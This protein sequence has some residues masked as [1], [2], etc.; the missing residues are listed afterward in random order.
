MNSGIRVLHVIGGPVT[1]GA[2]RGALW[3]HSGLRQRG[4]SSRVLVQKYAGSDAGIAGM[5]RSPMDNL[6]QISRKTLDSLPSLL[7]VKEKGNYFSPGIFG[8]DIRRHPWFD[9]ADMIHLHWINRAALNLNILSK[10]EKPIIWTLRDMWPMT[11]GCHYS[12]S[13]RKYEQRCGYCPQLKLR[14]RWDMSRLLI[15]RK[16]KLYPKQ[17]YPVAISHWLENCARQSYLLKDY[18]L[19]TIHNGIDTSVFYPVEK[20]D[21]RKTLNL[22]ENR[23]IILMGNF[24]MRMRYKGFEFIDK[25]IKYLGNKPYYLFF[26]S[27]DRGYLNSLGIEH[28]ATGYVANP[29]CLRSIYAAADI[30]VFP[31]IQEAFGKT[32]AESM[33]CGT[34]VAAFDSTGP[35]EIIQHMRTGYL[36]PPFDEAALA[37]GVLWLLHDKNRLTELSN[38]AALAVKKHFSIE[39]IAKMYVSFYESIN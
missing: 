35:K 23:E 18:H 34:P 25:I 9:W 32:V 39:T 13:C 21:A 5:S 11:G 8:F 29:E 27:A 26:G 20:C 12:L 37:E 30:Y 36:A 10:I 1:Y 19:R 2:A 38:A 3:L 24:D 22:P 16:K 14:G 4:L 15:E 7:F 28:T 17:L 31:S 33:S 6:L